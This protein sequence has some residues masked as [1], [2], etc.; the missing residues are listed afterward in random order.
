MTPYNPGAGSGGSK[1]Q[2][3]HAGAGSGGSKLQEGRAGAGSG[4]STLQEG[5]AGAGSKGLKAW[6]DGIRRI[7]SMAL[8]AVNLHFSL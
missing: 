7:D 6:G 1:L 8:R 2:E 3:G 4:G 5:H